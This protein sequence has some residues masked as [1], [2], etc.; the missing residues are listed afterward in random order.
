MPVLIK[1]ISYGKTSIFTR[2]RRIKA[3]AIRI[4]AVTVSTN[5]IFSSLG[6]KIRLL[7]PVYRLII[8]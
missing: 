5:V 2:K 1:L 8:A 4:A 3:A 7:F 6:T